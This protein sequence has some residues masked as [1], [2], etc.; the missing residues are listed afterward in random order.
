MKKLN[1]KAIALTLG[2]SIVGSMA[3]VQ[4]ASAD[5]N[6]FAMQKLDS[7]YQVAMEGKCGQGKCG[8]N[9]MKKKKAKQG[10]CGEGK[11]GANKMKMKKAQKEGKCG[12]NKMKMK[13]TKKEGKCGAAHMKTKEGKC[14]G[15]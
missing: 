3:S 2:A 5:S 14:G 15:M 1:S 12:A 6:P 4:L 11:C 10:K 7:G 9:M 8:A 13:K